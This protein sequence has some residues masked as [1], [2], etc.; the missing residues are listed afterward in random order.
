MNTERADRPILQISQNIDQNF[1]QKYTS[2]LWYI[3]G[4]KLEIKMKLVLF[5]DG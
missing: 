4:K 2:E 1:K 3:F 5:L